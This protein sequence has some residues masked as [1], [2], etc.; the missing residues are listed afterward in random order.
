MKSVCFETGLQTYTHLSFQTS[1]CKLISTKTFPK[2]INIG[3][4]IQYLWKYMRHTNW[5]SNNNRRKKRFNRGPIK[6]RSAIVIATTHF[7]FKWR[8]INFLLWLHLETKI[9]HNLSILKTRCSAL[10]NRNILGTCGIGECLNEIERNGKHW[11]YLGSMVFMLF[12]SATKSNTT[13]ST[14]STHENRSI[15]DRK[16]H[17]FC[18]HRSHRVER[19]WTHSKSPECNSNSNAKQRRLRYELNQNSGLLKWLQISGMRSHSITRI[20]YFT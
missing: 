14:S 7:F 3:G 6:T 4:I 12:S 16:S 5:I 11:W 2:D 17:E 1:T 9:I 18:A 10:L 20:H 8:P 19:H 13:A 15:H